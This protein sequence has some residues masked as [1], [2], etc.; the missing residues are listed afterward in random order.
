MGKETKKSE[1]FEVSLYGEGL[2]QKGQRNETDRHTKQGSFV[3]L[4]YVGQ[5]GFAIAIPIAGGAGIGSYLDGRWHTYPK[6]TLILLI[7]GIIISVFNFIT[8]IKEIIT[9][10]KKS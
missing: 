8:V 9:N 1:Q 3:Y 6:M 4:G 5:I 10:S 2:L 7:I